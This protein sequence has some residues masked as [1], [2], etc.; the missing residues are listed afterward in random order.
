MNEG[1][2]EEGEADSLPQSVEESKNNKITR[3]HKKECILIL[4]RKSDLAN[5]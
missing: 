5:Y 2:L 3:I 1:S 4:L